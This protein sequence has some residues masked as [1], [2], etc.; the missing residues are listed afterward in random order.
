MAHAIT[1]PRCRA[2]GA[3]RGLRLARAAC[4]LAAV[5]FALGA[6]EG[7]VRVRG[8]SLDEASVKTI[9][10]GQHT[11]EDV[12]ALLGTP[13]TVS[14][15]DD[16]KWYYIGQKSSQFAYH[17]PEVLERS[18]LVIAFDER[19]RV[20]DTELLSLEDGQEIDPVGRET[21]T[22]GRTFS[23]LQQLIGNIGRLPGQPGGI[24]MPGF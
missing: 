24:D 8:H 20:S 13:S 4:L 12:I 11:Q 18:V 10:N 3:G 16:R 22:E 9:T 2:E 5:G 17:A 14:T 1:M 19:G 21:P 15:F 6:C 7:T 23:V